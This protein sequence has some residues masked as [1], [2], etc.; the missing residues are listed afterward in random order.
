MRGLVQR[1]ASCHAELDEA[2]HVDEARRREDLRPSVLLAVHAVLEVELGVGD[3]VAERPRQGEVAHR[4][5]QVG[6]A[7]LDGDVVS[8]RGRAGGVGR[9]LEAGVALH[10]QRTEISERVGQLVRPLAVEQ[11]RLERRVLLRADLLGAGRRARLE[12]DRRDRLVHGVDEERV[13]E[14]DAEVVEAARVRLLGRARGDVQP[15][16]VEGHAET[17]RELL[18]EPEP[19]AQRPSVP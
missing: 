16:R 12:G 9:D 8:E 14:R 17:V 3:A 2:V 10:G 18:L 1:E 11:E 13:L 5:L 7:V 4:L 6:D 19:E 15:R